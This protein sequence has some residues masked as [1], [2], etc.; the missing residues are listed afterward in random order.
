MV[1]AIFFQGRPKCG[2]VRIFTE[3]KISEIRDLHL[4]GKSPQDICLLT[5]I[6]P[7]TYSKA[8]SEHR[9]V[10]PPQPGTI[11]G[12]STKSNR[13]I[14]DDESVLGKSC[15]NVLGRVLAI[16]EGR[17]A[18]PNFGNHPDLHHGGILLSLPSLI[19]SG[20]LN[21][22]DRFSDVKGYY[23]VEQVFISLS[24]LVLLRVRKLEQ[25]QSIPSGELGRC[26]G[27]DRIPEVK[28]LRKRISSFCI[29][30]DVKAWVSDLSS[31][32]MQH[33]TEAEGV[34]Y[35]DG[36]VNL[37]YGSQTQ[38]PR[39]FVSRM[40]LCLS[41]STDYRINDRLGQ[42]FFVVYKTL[43]E[44]MIKVMKD[45][46]IPRLD[47]EVSGQPS[48]A[49]L[50]TNPKLH[51]YMLVFDRE[52]YSIDFF[53]YLTE[54][55][56]AFC[57]YRK[58]VKEDRPDEEFTE[59]TT[60][61]DSG[62]EETLQLAQRETVLYG[63]KEKGEERKSVTVREIRKK[64]E[65]GHQTSIIT[66]NFMLS[67]PKLAL[68]M[69]ARWCQENFF[70]YMV[71]SFGIDSITSYLKN[72]LPDTSAIVN[73]A[74]KTLDQEHKKTSAL[75][76]DYKVKY[77]EIS[78]IDNKDFSEKQMNKHIKKKAEI[79]Q[80]IEALQKKKEDII[81]KKKNT[82]KKI[83]FN[84]LDVNKK[85]DSSLNDRKFFPDTIKIIAYRAETAMVNLIKKQMANPEQARSL[86][87]KF[88]SADADIE[89]DNLQ[90][91]LLIKLH[92]TNLWAD[93]MLLEY[94]CQQLNDT[95]TVFPDSNL[96]LRF[97]LL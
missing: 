21:H 93:D 39:R 51:R 77:A 57:T 66:T 89:V 86:I 85:F 55:R 41:G 33:S 65:S 97:A 96:T 92:R 91:L 81:E 73:P 50:K 94:L 4:Q 59:Y 75:L 30:T 10:L 74:Y 62:E 43:N 38:M 61:D 83:T 90:N 80:N 79:Q 95:M 52:G 36:H 3:E 6:K 16:R 18:L 34:L 88:Y 2:R 76:S 9:L 27:L 35:V 32:W 47:T 22:T 71:E 29:A 46:I 24:F 64:S 82:S 40:R 37:Y 19:A 84:E 20:L 60:I 15:T 69:F 17:T 28:T 26:I 23:S 70:K 56:I 42:P 44:G 12:L 67:T 11:T 45:E 13:N 72:K 54:K 53:K 48:A 5:G 63:Q 1:P 31:Q 25:S 78:L 7:N 68:L 87:R 58:N 8:L 14:Q 49:E